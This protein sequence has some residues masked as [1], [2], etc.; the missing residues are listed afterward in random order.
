M[1]VQCPQ[2]WRRYEVVLQNVAIRHYQRYISIERLQLDPCLRIKP[3]RLKD[4]NRS[5]KCPLFDRVGCRFLSPSRGSVWLRKY[6]ND[7]TD[8]ATISL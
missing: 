3:F 4:R 7:P 8:A 2:S 5:L 1:Q 6:T